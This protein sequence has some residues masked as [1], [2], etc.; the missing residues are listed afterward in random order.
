[1]FVC[2]QPRATEVKALQVGSEVVKMP[3]TSAGLKGAD[4]MIIQSTGIKT[5][6]A[7][8][9]PG[10]VRIQS[11]NSTN[12]P[13]ILPEYK[14][15]AT[16]DYSTS[17]QNQTAPIQAQVILPTVTST[18]QSRAAEL[19]AA[20]SADSAVSSMSTD[21]KSLDASQVSFFVSYLCFSYRFEILQRCIQSAV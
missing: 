12:P 2:V 1:M 21:S 8:A 11:A 5:P 3:T 17:T 18:V 6:P 10:S 16:T 7:S 9:I 15:V 20:L 19:K 4:N 14:P 13:G